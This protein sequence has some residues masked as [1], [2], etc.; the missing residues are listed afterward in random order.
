MKDPFADDE[1][2]DDE[3]GSGSDDGE[4]D[5]GGVSGWQRGGWWRGV[6]RTARGAG[7]EESTERFGDG[8]DDDSDS[9]GAGS[10][11]GDDVMDD[12]EFGDFAMPEVD[13]AGRQQAAAS[14]G[15]F[16]AA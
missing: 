9:D 7:K 3:N 12:E 4:G 8:R 16:Y 10:E 2:D 15:T 5:V 14:K 13:A 11:D 6:V 1:E